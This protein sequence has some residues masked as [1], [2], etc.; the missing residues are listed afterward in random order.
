MY[1]FKYMCIYLYI[2]IFIQ[3]CVSLYHVIAIGYSLQR[4][5]NVKSFWEFP[6]P[7][8]Q[9]SV[10]FFARQQQG[11]ETR[12]GHINGSGLPWPKLALQSEIG[13]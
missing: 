11:I 13:H 12:V 9:V 7:K 3:Y 1:I 10:H 8:S 2:H 6:T 4:R 5:V